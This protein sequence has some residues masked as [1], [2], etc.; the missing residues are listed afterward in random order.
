MSP[1][2]M[3]EVSTAKNNSAAETGQ[4]PHSLLLL[5]VWFCC[6]SNLSTHSSKSQP[7][8]CSGCQIHPLVGTEHRNSLPHTLCSVLCQGSTSSQCTQAPLPCSPAWRSPQR[9]PAAQAF[10]EVQH[11]TGSRGFI[12]ELHFQLAQ[13][14]AGDSS[15]L[16]TSGWGEEVSTFP[17]LPSRGCDH[18]ELLAQGT[19]TE[20]QEQQFP[21]GPPFSPALSDP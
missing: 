4:S 11:Y 17:S 1:S 6:S 20:P 15:L 19:G 12:P 13:A 2:Q 5:A 7:C 21:K 3:A 9:A 18:T 16:T 8:S 14:R 10:T